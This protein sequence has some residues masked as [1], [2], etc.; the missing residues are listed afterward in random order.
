VLLVGSIASCPDARPVALG[1]CPV[2]SI[3]QTNEQN[4]NSLNG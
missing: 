4:V 1:K 2:V 3:H